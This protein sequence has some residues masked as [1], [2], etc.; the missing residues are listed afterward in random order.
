MFVSYEVAVQLIRELR[1]VYEVMRRHD[2]ELAEQ[3][4][5]AANSIT[6]NLGE[7]AGCRGGR[8]QQHYEIAHGSAREVLACMDC[9]EAWGWLDASSV[10]PVLDRLLGLL[11]GLTRGAWV[12]TYRGKPISDAA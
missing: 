5:D 11:W 3:M 7:G 4:R 1:G 12:R 6:L 2:K 8:R 9:G 10:R